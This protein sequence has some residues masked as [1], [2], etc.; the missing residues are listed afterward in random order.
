MFAP[1]WR[2]QA[3]ANVV[4]SAVNARPCINTTRPSILP[5]HSTFRWNKLMASGKGL[6]G[7]GVW[8]ASMLGN[9]DTVPITRLS[10]PL[11]RLYPGSSHRYDVYLL[12]RR[13]RARGDIPGSQS[14]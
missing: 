4:S 2:L 10:E 7:Y 14:A 3:A 6:R 9:E 1:A 11:G 13:A 12:S 5:R 8:L